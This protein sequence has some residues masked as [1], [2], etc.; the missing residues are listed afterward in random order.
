MSLG[1]L[2][3]L[4]PWQQ[5]YSREKVTAGPTFPLTHWEAE[6]IENALFQCPQWSLI[7]SETFS[8]KIL[9]FSAQIVR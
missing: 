8:T 2:H 1:G 9:D 7:V 4:S 6:T 5:S 3:V